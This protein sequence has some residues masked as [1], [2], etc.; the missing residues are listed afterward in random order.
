MPLHPV[1]N[2]GL[3]FTSLMFQVNY[4]NESHAVWEPLIE[5][6]DN[7]KRR[8]NLGI[9]VFSAWLHRLITCVGGCIKVTCCTCRSNV[10]TASSASGL[11][12]EQPCL[13]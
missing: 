5:R 7:G 8:W 4:F 13:G 3:F 9:E 6:V 12:K 1:V 11:D 2:W 10:F